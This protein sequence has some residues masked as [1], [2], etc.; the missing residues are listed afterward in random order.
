MILLMEEIRRTTWDVKN[1]TKNGMNYQ[2]QLVSW[3]SSINSIFSK[4]H[5]V[6]LIYL[7]KQ[8]ASRQLLKVCTQ[9]YLQVPFFQ[10]FV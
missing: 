6:S 5:K 2:P 9:K 3:I 10:F 7:R 4:L 1:P 8:E